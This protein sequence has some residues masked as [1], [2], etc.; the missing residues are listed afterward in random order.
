MT[1]RRG[2]AGRAER[3]GQQEERRRHASGSPLSAVAWYFVR[4][5]G[6]PPAGRV[7][8]ICAE[9]QP[10]RPTFR[11]FRGRSLPRSPACR[12]EQRLAAQALSRVARVKAD[13]DALWYGKLVMGYSSQFILIG[14]TREPLLRKRIGLFGNVAHLRRLRPIENHS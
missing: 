11:P 4:P 8:L 12:Q 9:A 2:A 5:A 3:R 10:S 13:W 7:T 1:V 6:H 14:K